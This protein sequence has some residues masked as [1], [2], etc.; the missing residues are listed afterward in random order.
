MKLFID[1]W[2]WLALR[3]KQEARHKEIDKFYRNFRKG[4]G[5]IYTTD[6]ILD[7]TFTLLFRRLPFYKAKE[8]LEMLDK[9]VQK[10][11]LHTE[12][13][14]PERFEQA[15]RL[16]LKFQHKPRISFTDFTSMVVMKELDISKILTE[17]EHFIKV[18]MG[19]QIVP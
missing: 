18:G 13:V 6:Y 11:Y 4:R 15:K 7:E 2:G 14:T 1:T 8:S 9:A 19:F 5:T 3:D 17:D 16:R 12:L 10:G